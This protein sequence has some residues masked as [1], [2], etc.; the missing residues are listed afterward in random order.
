MAIPFF[1]MDLFTRYF[2]RKINFFAL[3]DLVPNLF[4]FIWV[5]LILGICLSF[6]NNKRKIVYSF[7]LVISSIPLFSTTFALTSIILLSACTG[8]INNIIN[9]NVKTTAK[10]F[11]AVQFYR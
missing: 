10:Y 9:I 11:A 4:T 5:I 1:I 3:N 8:I 6:K 2:G 7:F